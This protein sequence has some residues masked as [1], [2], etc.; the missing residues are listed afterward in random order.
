MER[1][2][3]VLQVSSLTL[4]TTATGACTPPPMAVPQ[5]VERAS[6]E[7]LITDRSRASGMFV[8]ES[9][10]IGPY[11][12]TDVNRKWNSSSSSSFL[13]VS[14]G[15]SKGGYSYGLKAPEGEYKAA[16]TSHLDEK[17]VGVLGGAFGS[18]NYAVLCQCG[19]PTLATFSMS[20]DSSSRYKGTVVAGNDSYAIEGIY[21]YEKGGTSGNPLGYEVRGAT[22]VGAV[23]VMGK[24]RVWLSKSLDPIARANVACLFAGLLLY[25]APQS[26]VNK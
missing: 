1:S 8:D 5:D 26:P 21:T 24:G 20:A 18:Q 25:Q 7:I 17:S 12:I 9:F 15:E 22:P 10:T 23:E 3:R 13:S 11:R 16:C 6:D 4:L 2:Q 19:G 14:S